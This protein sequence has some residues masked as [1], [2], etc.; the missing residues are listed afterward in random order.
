MVQCGEGRGYP[1][2]NEAGNLPT[3]IQ[4]GVVKRDCRA[5]GLNTGDAVDRG[6]CRNLIHAT[7]QIKSIC[8]SYIQQFKLLSFLFT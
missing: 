5:R 3:S 7:N 1:L 2:P 6:G 8:N 4:V